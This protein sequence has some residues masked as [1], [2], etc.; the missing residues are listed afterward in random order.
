M[1]QT[2]LIPANVHG[3]QGQDCIQATWSSIIRCDV[4]IKSPQRDPIIY[5]LQGLPAERQRLLSWRFPQVKG[6]DCRT[7]LKEFRN[8]RY[9]LT[10]G[11]DGVLH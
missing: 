2:G 4:P 9:E 8:L 1:P 3:A 11:S 7:L 10:G 6:E 5:Y